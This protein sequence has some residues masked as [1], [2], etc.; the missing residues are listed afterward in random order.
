MVNCSAADVR[1]IIDT[2]LTDGNIGS[3]ITL[4]DAE[5]TAR[6]LDEGASDVKKL[7]SMLITASL[8]AMRDPATKSIGEYT[9]A[10]LN[11]EGWRNL[12]ETHISHLVEI[13]FLAVNDPID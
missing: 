7:I 10:K 5:M 12:A 6:G 4:A 2:S 1:L 3:L 11:A 13:P 9:E 8:C